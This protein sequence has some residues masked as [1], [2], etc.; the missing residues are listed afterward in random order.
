MQSVICSNEPKCEGCNKCIYTCPVPGANSSY[1]KGEKSVT[2]VDQD[3]CIMCGQCV[4]TCDHGAREFSDDLE[5]F[6]EDLKRG[7]ALSLIAAPAFKINYPDY[8]KFFGYLKSIGV[9]NIYDVSLGADITTWAYLKAI[10]QYHLDSVIAQPCPAVVN[11]I[12]KY[13]HDLI[14]NL[15]PVQSPMMCT[16]IYLKKYMKVK[17]DLVFLSPCI[18]KIS[19]IRDPNTYDYIKYN[20]T[21]KKLEDYV[22]LN[23]IDINSFN[24]ADYSIA[25][26]SLGEIYSTPGGLKENVYLYDR[27]AF[28]KQVEG[29]DAAY[30][31][32]EEYASRKASGKVL[33]LLVD[34]LN[35]PNGCNIGSAT[36]K[37]TDI[38]DVELATSALRNKKTGR[39]KANPKK[40]LKLFDSKLK[41][42][43]FE[44]TYLK[45]DLP[46]LKVPGS[47]ELDSIYN[48][49]YKF[50]EES[51]K[52]NCF[53]CGYGSCY[54]MAVAI[55]NGHNH[56]ENCI[57]FNIKMSAERITLEHRNKEI[58]ELLEKV[59]KMSDERKQKFELLGGRIQDITKAIE[60]M[61]S[62]SNENSSSINKISDSVSTLAELSAQLEIKIESMQGFIN[63]FNHVTDEL[64]QIADQTNMLSLNASIEASRAGEAGRGFSVVAAEV[65]KL[66]EQSRHAVQS[67]EADEQM[68]LE[69]IGKIAEISA[70]L[71]D[72]AKNVNTEILS[73]SAAMQEIT[74]KNQEILNT[75]NLIVEEQ[76]S[77]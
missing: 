7:R 71:E 48:Q 5:A 73:I 35:C 45:E 11:Y 6:L 69:A 14:P 51:R 77:I 52:R 59:E 53:A 1:L 34:I 33:P 4:D 15:A 9:Q 43:D 19:E 54:E 57:D 55:Y 60:E 64:V 74:A 36:S 56:I 29:A 16:A 12:Q 70:I 68:L 21:F 18:A 10:K 42:S 75:A 39:Y 28:I 27:S 40:L 22:K 20:V 26:Y 62:S 44:R 63:N 67:T 23:N 13:R 72:R 38:T 47:D 61:A 76:S 3:R 50:T 2:T 8:K 37:S 31:Y 24:E 58:T 41:L 49:M 30:K 32:I 65:K 25:A 46:E 17:E 66:A